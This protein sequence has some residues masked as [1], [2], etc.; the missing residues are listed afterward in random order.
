MQVERAGVRR[1][2]VGPEVNL[3]RAL[4][5]DIA[6]LD[7]AHGVGVAHAGR[8]RVVDEPDLVVDEPAGRGA[9][10]A[11]PDVAVRSEIL[12]MLLP[13]RDAVAVIGGRIAARV[14]ERVSADHDQHARDEDD[15]PATRH[16]NLRCRTEK[17]VPPSR[18]GQG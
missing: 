4:I 13:R 18:S 11:D 7:P 10:V 8:R 9:Q 1:A 17:I 16:S 5:R 6:G 2:G 14:S 3:A 15:P 12:R